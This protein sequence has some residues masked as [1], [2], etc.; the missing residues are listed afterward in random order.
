[1]CRGSAPAQAKEALVVSA[2]YTVCKVFNDGLLP[3]FCLALKLGSQG[4]TL[5][6]VFAGDATQ[7]KLDVADGLIL[8]SWG[9]ISFCAVPFSV[10]IRQRII[11]VP[12]LL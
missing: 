4:A 3:L 12:S 9:K 6:A 5:V 2:D 8:G 11:F 1:M 10:A 7:E